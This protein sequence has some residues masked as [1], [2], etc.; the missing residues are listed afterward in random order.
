MISSCKGTKERMQMES[1]SCE[2]FLQGLMKISVSNA[3]S[4]ILNIPCNG[5]PY[6]L[7]SVSL[8][9]KPNVLPFAKFNL[10]SK[11]IMSAQY[12]TFA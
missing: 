12:S 6:A 7:L 4:A 1:C 10:L 8:R 3:L 2:T 9:Y 11:D 5:S